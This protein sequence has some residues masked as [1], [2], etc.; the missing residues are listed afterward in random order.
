MLKNGSK[1][2]QLTLPSTEGEITIPSKQI[3]CL[4]V[5]RG[6]FCPTT[7]KFL[8]AYQ[9]IYGRLK[10]INVSLLSLSTDTLED[11]QSL[12][13]SLSLSFPLVSDE[14]AKA[15]DLY[16]IYFEQRKSGRGFYEPAL[17]ITDIDQNIAYSVI[18]SGPKGLPAPGDVLPVLLFMHTHGGRY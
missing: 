7:N 11:N 10:E 5:Q 16:Q 2:P 6:K 13:S 12:K 15:A 3:T 17:F 14:E 9:D 1:A 18:S 8:T 4:I